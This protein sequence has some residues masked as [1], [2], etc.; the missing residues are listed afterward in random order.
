MNFSAR[1][2]AVIKPFVRQLRW[3]QRNVHR[4]CLRAAARIVAARLPKLHPK[5][6]DPAGPRKAGNPRRFTRRDRLSLT[7]RSPATGRASAIRTKARA[8]LKSSQKILKDNDVS[9]LARRF[10]A[11]I[12]ND[13]GHLSAWPGKQREILPMSMSE[14][15]TTAPEVTEAPATEPAAPEPAATEATHS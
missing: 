7:V 8:T 9:A 11:A 12:S 1:D 15:T 10:P 2:A 13:H 3:R 14:A 6:I 4:G 5:S